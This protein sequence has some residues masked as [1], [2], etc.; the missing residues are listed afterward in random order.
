MRI[1]GPGV[2]GRLSFALPTIKIDFLRMIAPCGNPINPTIQSAN[3]NQ[4]FNMGA[5]S[6]VARAAKPA[7]PV[8]CFACRLFRLSPV[9]RRRVFVFFQTGRG[10]ASS[11]GLAACAT[12]ARRAARVTSA[13]HFNLN[14]QLKLAAKPLRARAKTAMQKLRCK[15]WN[16]KIGTLAAAFCPTFT[17]EAFIRG[18]NWSKN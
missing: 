11:A 14:S 2:W 17:Q 12:Y 4:R 5:H 9:A 3:F 15:N 18:S 7:S 1:I 6:I 13:L 16:A 8:A 10:F